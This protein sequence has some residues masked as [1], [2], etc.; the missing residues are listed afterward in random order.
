MNREHMVMIVTFMSSSLMK[1][2]LSARMANRKDL[3]DEALLRELE[4]SNVEH[5]LMVDAIWHSDLDGW[6]C[7]LK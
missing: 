5:C 6:K 1:L 7:T 2:L 4:G 3:L